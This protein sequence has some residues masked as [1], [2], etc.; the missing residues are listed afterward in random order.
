MLTNTEFLWL[1]DQRDA[2]ER[3]N[4]FI[5]LLEGEGDRELWR[6]HGAAILARWIVERPGTRPAT[7]WRYDAPLLP[8]AVRKYGDWP[9]VRELKE[10]RRQIGGGGKPARIGSYGEKETWLGGPIYW[11]GP[12]ENDPP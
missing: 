9:V 6:E 2:A 3:L 8:N 10:P 4:P 1:T 5:F 11:R 7:W 12:D